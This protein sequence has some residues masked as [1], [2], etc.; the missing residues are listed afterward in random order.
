MIKHRIY[1]PLNWID[2]EELCLKL[3]GQIWQIPNE[4]DFNSI[5]SQGQNGVDIYGIPKGE[6]LHYGIQ[7]KNFKEEKKSGAKNKI[8]KTIIDTEIKNAESF[9]PPLKHFIIA[10]SLEKDK[11]IEEY[12]RKINQDRLENNQFTVQICFWEYITQMLY[13]HQKIYNWYCQNQNLSSH[14]KV[15]I[16]F[17]N[18]SNP[19]RIK[20]Q[21]V[22][23]KIKKKYRLQTEKDIENE[24][25]LNDEAIKKVENYFYE[26]KSTNFQRFLNWILKRKISDRIFSSKQ[27]IINGVDIR[28]E[29][30]QKSLYPKEI[31][32]H[33]D[34]NFFM[35][36]IAKDTCPLHFYII[37]ENTGESVL[38]DYKLRLT[39]EGEF[40]KLD[41]KMP[42]ISEVLSKTVNHNVFINS[43]SCL[44]QPNN[45]FLVQKDYFISE[46]I[47]ITPTLALKTE[48]KIKWEF[49]SRD[50]N[51]KGELYIDIEPKFEHK[52]KEFLVL[53]DYECKEIEDI[54]F[55][56][57]KYSRIV[58]Y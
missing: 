30:Y 56:T 28:S 16:L 42:S 8:T 7:C 26:N 2:F 27:I 9:T 12:V 37:I 24:K 32:D 49:I 40:D 41:T 33:S 17:N 6:K 15:S 58:N 29:E 3:W 45:N 44:I 53:N 57:Y 10:T 5:N 22:Y 21:P 34:I 14:K 18:D 55:K 23:L 19:F 1:P 13:D 36:P 43:K 54:D 51:D 48:I 20:H 46:Q 35:N 4:I 31:T 39:F 52:T 38:E 11:S 50:Y 47:I 25:R